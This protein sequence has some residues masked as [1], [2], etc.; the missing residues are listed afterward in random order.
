[1]APLVLDLRF[2]SVLKLSEEGKL[3]GLVVEDGAAIARARDRLFMGHHRI[4]IS[5]GFESRF[6][7]PNKALEAPET[8]DFVLV[9]ELGC[10]ERASKMV[11]RLVIG[12]QRHRKWM[13]I[14]AA[15]R[16]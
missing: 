10:I 7:L 5:F 11:K 8:L 1:M 16:E 9:A 3:S 2:F 13:S 4:E 15:V 6:D 12:L 14:L